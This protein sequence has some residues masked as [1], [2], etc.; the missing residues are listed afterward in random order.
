MQLGSIK[1]ILVKYKYPVVILAL[2]L[3]FLLF[4]SDQSEKVTAESEDILLQQVLAC[5]KGV[6]EARLIS[7][8]NGVVISCEGA[9]N[10]QVRLEI[11]RAVSSYTGF[12]S[13][14]ITILK[15]VK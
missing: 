5:S 2:G 1:E 14:K 3:V 15:M 12:S 10:A 8:E 6:G 13:D 4:P 7:S 9:N 11:I